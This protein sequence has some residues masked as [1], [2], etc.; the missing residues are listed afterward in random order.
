MKAV[1]ASAQFGD[2]IVV[3]DRSPPRLRPTHLLVRTIA[4]AAN[5]ADV[6][7][8]TYG[9]AAKGSLLGH[10]YASIV[11]EKGS[12]VI[13]DFKVGDRVCGCTR[14]G[15]PDE[16]E[17][18]TAAEFIAVKADLQVKVPDGM[19]FEEAATLGVTFLTTGRCLY[20]AF[21]VPFPE[22]ESANTD[23]G[24][25]FIYGGSSAMGTALT[26]FAKLSGFTVITV[27]SPHNFEL[28]KS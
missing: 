18:G 21:D 8:L 16:L 20:K 28:C 1:I 23:R 10:D 15:D 22:A 24:P 12:D 6:L 19:T 9:L 2:T 13:R 26:Q 3:H 25:L 14:G 11:Q 27:C 7:Y 4:V 5:P 17:N